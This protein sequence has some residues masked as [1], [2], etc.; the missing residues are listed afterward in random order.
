MNSFKRFFPILLL[1]SALI[2]SSC[3]GL[4]K[5]DRSG[6][7]VSS[8][9]GKRYN[10]SFVKKKIAL[11]T[12]FNE[13]PYGGNDLEITATEE[14]RKELSF[15]GEFIVDHTGNKLFGTSKEIFVGGGLKL[16]QLSRKA[17]LSGLNF[18]LFGR[19]KHARVREKNDE[20]GFIR[21]TKS[22]ADVILELRIFSVNSS[23][24]V[25]NRKISAQIDDNTYRIYMSKSEDKLKY[26]QNLLRY[27]TRVA[28]RKAIPLI[29]G[30]SS[31]MDWTGRVAKIMGSKVYINAGRSSGINVG[32]ILRI[33]TEGTEIYD[34]ETGALI[35]ISKGEVKGT[36]EII[37][38][39]GPDGSISILHS[40]G[41]V[42]EG[43]F[44]QLY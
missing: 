23:K 4:I 37:D 36:L 33:I 19:I 18:V 15:T 42:Q 38:Y 1:I 20:I 26:R 35:G 3:G 22:Y 44:V 12:I 10:L 17:K 27:V 43:D 6:T 28:I 30:V 13:A 8:R 2:L 7:R 16:S 11:L 25:F 31:K 34:P 41:S 29:V 32:D 21:K 9:R 39:F 14:L 5:R 40:G 24:E